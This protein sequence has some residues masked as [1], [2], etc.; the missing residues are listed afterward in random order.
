MIRALVHWNHTG[1][2]TL[3]GG[4]SGVTGVFA[5]GTG[6]NAG[7]N[8][9][10]AV[11]VDSSGNIYCADYVNH[12]IRKVTPVGG[13]GHI[14]RLLEVVR[15]CRGSHLPVVL[16]V[17]VQCLVTCSVRVCFA[18]VDVQIGDQSWGEEFLCVLVCGRRPLRGA[19]VITSVFKH[20]C[21]VL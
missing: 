3:G 17:G 12:R 19:K 10:Y 1:V 20:A 21:S 9:P 16:N 13:T 8:N 4:K 7:F 5:D 14:A 2:S 6:S 18:L 15:V 11:A